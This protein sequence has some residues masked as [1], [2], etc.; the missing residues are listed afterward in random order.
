[1]Q[2]SFE[3]RTATRADGEAL[4][5][6]QAASMRQLTS[7]FYEP[8][9][10]EAFILQGTM[11]LALLEGGR[12]FVAHRDGRILGSGGWSPELPRY[13]QSLKQTA[14]MPSG[15]TAIVR[16]FYVHPAA[17]RQ[18]VAS[19]LMARTEQAISSAGFDT[20][21]LDAMLPAV[22]F[23][24]QQGWRSDQPVVLGLPGARTMVGLGMTKRLRGRWPAAA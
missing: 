15:P 9:V 10:I 3:I 12:Y 22:P 19:A 23:Y 18:G 21:R 7:G 20:A 4:L 14:L 1:M 5:A 6:M 16:C 8:G 2:T 17:A 24:R 13:H 11:E